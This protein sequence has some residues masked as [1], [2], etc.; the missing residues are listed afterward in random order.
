MLNRYGLFDVDKFLREQDAPP[1]PPGQDPPQGGSPPPADGPPPP[2]PEDPDEKIKGLRDKQRDEDLEQFQRD[3]GQSVYRLVRIW[4]NAK[5][6]PESE[7]FAL[8]AALRDLRSKYYDANID[9]PLVSLLTTDLTGLKGAEHLDFVANIHGGNA[10][11]NKVMFRSPGDAQKFAEAM[12]LARPDL[13]FDAVASKPSVLHVSKA[14]PPEETQPP[15]EQP[16][17]QEPPLPQQQQPP[18]PGM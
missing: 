3:H 12:Q 14:P 11:G 16:P 15:Q 4:R 8:D 7:R 6:D 17:Q 2:P 9:S 13:T 5:R 10:S 18:Q 1:P